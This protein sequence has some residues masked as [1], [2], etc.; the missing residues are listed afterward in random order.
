MEEQ[1]ILRFIPYNRSLVEYAKQN[2]KCPTKAEGLFWNIVLK[3]KSF[4]GYRFRRQRVIGSFILDFYCPKLLLGIEIDGDYHNEQEQMAYDKMRE[5]MI[6]KYGI[7][8][9]R[10]TNEEVEKN[11]NKVKEELKEF[12]QYRELELNTK[13]KNQYL[14]GRPT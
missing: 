11:L 4:G 2:R 12:V 14:S 5:E 6:T 10:F 8:M 13:P 7:T 9:L 1:T 3:D